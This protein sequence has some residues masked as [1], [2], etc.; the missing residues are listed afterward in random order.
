MKRAVQSAQKA[1]A[2]GIRVQ[3]SGRLGGAEMSRTEWYR[4]GR[5]PLHTLRADIDAVIERFGLAPF[6]DKRTG[7]LSHGWKQRVAIASALCHKPSVLLLDEVTAGIDPDARDD[8]W[9]IL[10][11]ASRHGTA[12]I[13]TTHF[14]DEARHCHRTGYLRDGS[15][16]PGPKTAEAGR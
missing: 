8:M 15:L 5:V 7:L 1:G 3:C 11:D 9:A 12:I 13:L 14:T 4:E 16:G 10:A 6:R 2:L